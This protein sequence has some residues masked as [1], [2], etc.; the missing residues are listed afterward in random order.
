MPHIHCPDCDAIR[1][2]DAPA[3]PECGRCAGCGK[4]LTGDVQI[5]ECGFPGDEK[6]AR[7]IKAGYGI[8]EEDVER[9]KLKWQKRKKCE[10]YLLAG[11]ILLLAICILLGTLTAILVL[12]DADELVK[13]FLGVPVV[14]L[15]TLFYWVF[16][17]GVGKIFMWMIRLMGGKDEG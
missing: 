1:T 5:C 9:E 2:M 8:A 14:C 7:R 13:I 10:P 17:R 4:K 15:L 11:R 3:C 6:I 16:F 12:S